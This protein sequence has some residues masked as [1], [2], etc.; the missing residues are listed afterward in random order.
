MNATALPLPRHAAQPLTEIL[1]ALLHAAWRRRYLILLPVLVLPLLGGALGSF[2]PRSYEA[3]MSVLVQDPQRFNPFMTDLTVRSNL[4]DRMDGLKALLT[5][6]HVLIGVAEDIGLVARGA[7][8]A[9]QAW[10]V[11]SLAAAVSVTLIGQ[12]MVELRYR[13]RSPEGMDDVLRRIGER[14]IERVRGPEDTSLRESVTFLE[15]QAAESQSELDVA[16]S[17]LSAFK[18]RNASQLPDLRQAN[19]SRLATLREQLSERELRLA[20]ACCRPIR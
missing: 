6:R 13:A 16:E 19:V 2:A 17:A 20:S 1:H 14:F 11:S 15:R 7:P 18:S 9:A 5:S 8:E 10:A 4:R 3:R 12:E